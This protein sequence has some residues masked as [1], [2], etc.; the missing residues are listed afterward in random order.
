MFPRLVRVALL[1]VLVV[2]FAC[3]GVDQTGVGVTKSALGSPATQTIM[4]QYGAG[5]P[6]GRITHGG[7][8][9]YQTFYL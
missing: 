4:S 1:L 6:I 3:S 2:A 7:N 9:A 8:G 5:Y